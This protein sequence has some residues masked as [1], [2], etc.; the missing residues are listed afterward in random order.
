MHPTTGSKDKVTN[1]KN[2]TRVTSRTTP[3]QKNVSNTTSNV[4]KSVTKEEVLGNV[5]N[6]TLTK[7]EEVI[8]TNIQEEKEMALVEVTATSYISSGYVS[9]FALV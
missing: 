7:E 4:K 3:K 9:D 1:E 8:E 2:T 6:V 5:G